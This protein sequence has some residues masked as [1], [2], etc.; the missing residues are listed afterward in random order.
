[1]ILKRRVALD[2]VYLD[3]VDSRILISRVEPA[4]GAE[5]IGAV[6][7]AGRA[8]QRMTGR[9]RGTKDVA[10]GFRINARGRSTDGMAA[11]AEVFEKAT[12]WAAAG[13]YL[14]VNYKPGRRMRVVMAQEPTEGSLWDYTR[15]F[16]ITFRAYGVPYWEDAEEN[17]EEIGEGTEGSAEI[18]IGGSAE[19]QAEIEIAN[20]GDGVID[21]C[22]VTVGGKTMTFSG[23]ALAASETLVIDHLDGLVRLYA[24]DGISTRSLMANRTGAGD[25]LAA[26]G[27]QTVSFSAD[28]ACLATVKWRNR[29]L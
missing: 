21:S 4:A 23:I 14:T 26:P 22:V 2:G 9:H 12:A 24:R 18:L 1:M 10:V 19:T 27:Y 11:R 7:I 8:G 13:G 29:Y 5:D 16:V 25:F 3:Q 17:T 6:D 20:A 28:G 15:E